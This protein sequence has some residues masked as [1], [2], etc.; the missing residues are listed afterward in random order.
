METAVAKA[1]NKAGWILRTFKTRSV[2]LMRTLWNSL[3]Q[4]H[5]DYGSVLW[6]PSDVKKHL[7][8]C[9]SPLRSFTKK[10]WGLSNLN[11]WERLARFKVN[12]FQRRMERYKVTYI[13]KSL[14]G[15]VPS[16]GCEWS[17]GNLRNRN[18]L[19]LPKLIGKIDSMK[20]AQRRSLKFEGVMLFNS[21]PEEVRLWTGSQEVFKTMLDD[22]LAVIPDQP[23][24]GSLSPGG[25]TEDGKASNSIID[26]ISFLRDELPDHP[27]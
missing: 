14:N 6:S 19:K 26:W 3:V 24:T 11:Y 7:K 20:S 13:W 10:A 2:E 12:S 15:L 27:P 4:P 8:F 5:L 22:Y 16:L 23:E 1:K 18:T 9:E 25:R 21:V 17:D